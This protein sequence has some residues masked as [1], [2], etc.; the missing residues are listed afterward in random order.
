MPRQFQIQLEFSAQTKAIADVNANLER[1]DVASRKAGVSLSEAFAPAN[2]ST[3]EGMNQRLILGGQALQNYAKSFDETKI[4]AGSAVH[5][6]QQ[7]GIA[8]EQ[9]ARIGGSNV[10]ALDAQIVRLKAITGLGPQMS[11]QI[12][13]VTASLG[14]MQTVAK[15]TAGPAGISS[16]TT[17][18]QAMVASFSVGQLAAG[19]FE[20]AI[21]GLG[22]SALFAAEAFKN[23]AFVGLTIAFSALQVAIPKI[24]G[25]FGDTATAAEDASET[26]QKLSDALDEARG[27][28]DLAAEGLSGLSREAQNTGVSF[29]ALIDQHFGL[30]DALNRLTTAQERL[31]T[32]QANSF[33]GSLGRQGVAFTN[34]LTA[35]TENYASV[36]GEAASFITASMAQAGR[37]FSSAMTEFTTTLEREAAL[38]S[39]LFPLDAEL[40][41]LSTGLDSAREMFADAR[42]ATV[43]AAQEAMRLRTDAIREGLRLEV[44]A[45]N[46]ALGEMLR[47]RR[48]ALEEALQVIDEAHDA[49]ADARQDDLEAEIKVL[50]DGAE[51]LID[52]REDALDAELDLIKDKAE[53]AVDAVKD[54]LDNELEAIKDAEDIRIDEIRDAADAELDANRD[55]INALKDAERE[56]TKDIADVASRRSDL[57]KDQFALAG[58]LAG[59]EALS[60]RIGADAALEREIAIRK[61]II[62]AIEDEKDALDDV[63]DSLDEKLTGIQ[64]EIEAEEAKTEIIKDLRDEE[65]KAA[66]KKFKEIIKEA[67]KAADEEIDA[68]KDVRDE[69]IDA[70]KERAKESIKAIKEVLDAA[71]DAAKDRADTD[72]EESRRAADERKT[73]AKELADEEIRQA[74]R[75]T[76]DLNIEAGKRSKEAVRQATISFNETKRLA[77]RNFNAAVKQAGDLNKAAINVVNTKKEQLVA[78]AR[79]SAHIQD[80]L[81]PLARQQIELA[82]QL[83]VAKLAD[84]PGLSGLITLIGFAMDRLAGSTNIDSFNDQVQRILAAI[85]QG[86]AISAPPFHQGGVVGGTIGQEKLIRV[87]AGEEVLAIGEG[88]NRGNVF[89]IYM[90]SPRDVA[91]LERV[92]SRSMG[93]KT[94]LSRRMGITNDRGR[95]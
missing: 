32:A 85:S 76:E 79:V 23:P 84:K 74:Q 57:I 24:K 48:K 87:R 55:R 59:L 20:Q 72:I 67:K 14:A 80:V 53:E 33:G 49:F 60:G 93:K 45:N 83:L 66:K 44:R 58:E 10:K 82:L 54:K 36:T 29:A 63:I 46:D 52:A 92:L 19:N 21:F 1:L 94:S 9:Q 41:A 5:E 37:E 75:A 25:L 65:I 15:S 70:A 73:I 40:A 18:G 8:I 56:L 26:V 62:D 91:K 64:D 4:S 86:L 50:Q 27:K 6:I 69:D 7:V 28:Y 95:I 42:D 47:A 34:E 51:A 17:A 68:I 13:N 90:S 81:L 71:E 39:R 12:N 89:N 16:I 31:N 11:A 88:N 30:T 77:D 3:I 43:E 2:L 38:E 61:G 35:A 22:F 78:E